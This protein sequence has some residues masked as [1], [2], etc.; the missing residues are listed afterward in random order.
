MIENKYKQD[1]VTTVLHFGLS[2]LMKTDHRSHRKYC[3]ATSYLTQFNNNNL[4]LSCF[5]CCIIKAK[6]TFI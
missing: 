4:L 5:I 6:Y 1:E 3:V 2:Y